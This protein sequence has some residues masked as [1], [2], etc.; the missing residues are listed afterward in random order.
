MM[1]I[2]VL[3]SGRGT[4]EKGGVNIHDPHWEGVDQCG[5][6]DPHETGKDDKFNITARYYINQFLIVLIP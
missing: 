1:K 2:A 3:V 5:G 6:D 4:R